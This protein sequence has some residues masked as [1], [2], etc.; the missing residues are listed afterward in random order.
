MQPTSKSVT[1]SNP[2]PLRGDNEGDLEFNPSPP[3][4]DDSQ[5][6]PS[7]EPKVWY[8]RW[9]QA[10]SG[11][12]SSIGDKFTA[13]WRGVSNAADAVARFFSSKGA[14]SHIDAATKHIKETTTPVQKEASGPTQSPQTPINYFPIPENAKNKDVPEER[15]GLLGAIPINPPTFTEDT[16]K[17]D[18]VKPAPAPASPGQEKF[19]A[20]VATRG[21]LVDV[22]QYAL[23][24]DCL[25]HAIKLSRLLSAAENTGSYQL[26]DVERAIHIAAKEIWSANADYKNKKKAEE[27][28]KAQEAE[29]VR[30]A[31]E[32]ARKQPGQADFEE[33]VAAFDRHR[34]DN[35]PFIIYD[36][37]KY[38]QEVC[39]QYGRANSESLSADHKS[40]LQYLKRW[41]QDPQKSKQRLEKATQFISL[42]EVEPQA[43]KITEA[44]IEALQIDSSSPTDLDVSR[45]PPP[46]PP[47]A[48]RWISMLSTMKPWD[49]QQI[50]R[51]A[52]VL[53]MQQDQ[54]RKAMDGLR[55][56]AKLASASG[57]PAASNAGDAHTIEQVLNY[58]TEA[59]RQA[60]DS[61]ESIELASR[62]VKRLID[63]DTLVFDHAEKEFFDSLKNVIGNVDAA[64]DKKLVELLPA[65]PTSATQEKIRIP[66]LAELTDSEATEGGRLFE[67]Y[68]AGYKNRSDS[69]GYAL[70]EKSNYFKSE[71]LAF[72]KA[73]AE[74]VERMPIGIEVD[75]SR[76]L[77]SLY[78]LDQARKR[79]LI[80]V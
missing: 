2:I 73:F 40:A 77:A 14:E 60:S 48:A 39:I 18:V 37:S 50:S 28:K 42:D 52:G 65:R 53:S 5:G 22:L 23:D 72:A 33:F 25:Q 64:L 1:H 54:V 74:Q 41:N 68:V 67:T 79:G 10:I 30:Q 56:I 46:P 21:E 36:G 38:L 61:L 71:C 32:A 3:R 16:E 75:S 12:F 17:T 24:D 7:A 4:P 55:A 78:L 8:V 43:S 70:P 9:G 35:T 66:S 19:D 13:L 31:E 26:N 76:L 45:P 59:S 29:R 62:L 49:S 47:P 80:A 44:T 63:G 27:Q 51:I 57:T 20:Y 58:D 15:R 34:A 11:F 69:V 6:I